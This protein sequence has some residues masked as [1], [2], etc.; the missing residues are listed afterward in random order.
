[1]GSILNKHIYYLVVDC[2]DPSRLRHLTIPVIHV[3]YVIKLIKRFRDLVRIKIDIRV[4]RIEYEEIVKYLRTL[5]RDYS[6]ED[7]DSSLPITMSR[8]SETTNEVNGSNG[9]VHLD[10]HRLL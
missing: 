6:I 5:K 9:V 10:I 7:D 8:R 2:L 1:M 4:T 3:S